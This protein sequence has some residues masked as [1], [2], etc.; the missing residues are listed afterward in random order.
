MTNVTKHLISTEFL[1]K[2]FDKHIHSVNKA[3][4][5]IDTYARTITTRSGRIAKQTVK[6]T[7]SFVKG[8]KQIIDYKKQME[9]AAHATRRMTKEQAKL[10]AQQTTGKHKTNDLVKALRRAVIVAPIWMAARAVMM[11]FLAAIKDIVKEYKELDEGMRKVMAVATYTSSTQAKTYAGLEQA[12][13]IYFATSS[14]GMKEIT[15]AMYQL[16]TA[17]RSTEEIMEGFE[18]ILNLTVATFGDVKIAGRITAGILN[19]FEDE[20][21]EI[22]GTSKQLQYISDL[23]TTAWK[24]NQIELSELNTAMGYLAS[25]G[26]VTGLGLKELVASASVMSDA[27]LRGGKGGRLLARSFI[28]IAKDSKKLKTLGVIF[29]PNKPLDFYNVMKQLRGIYVSQGKSLSFLNDMVGIFGTRGSRAVLSVLDQWQKF[30]EELHRTPEEIEGTAEALKNLAEK[31]W[32]ALFKKA[33][34]QAISTPVEGKGVSPLKEDIAKS[35]LM[36]DELTKAAVELQ[37]YIELQKSLGKE[38]KLSKF[39]AVKLAAELRKVKFL[40]LASEIEKLAKVTAVDRALNLDKA[41]AETKTLGSELL[42]VI[43]PIQALKDLG[44]EKH[45]KKAIEIEFDPGTMMMSKEMSKYGFAAKKAALTLSD[46]NDYFLKLAKGGES[47]KDITKD[48]WVQLELVLGKKTE[49]LEAGIQGRL[50]ELKTT[51]EVNKHVTELSILE[52]N[53]ITS[54]REGLSYKQ[55]E[56]NSYSK[57]QVLMKKITDEI[58][59]Q[60]K[61]INEYNKTHKKDNRETI[62]TYDILSG[63]AEK[64]KASLYG[65]DDVT[66]LIKLGGDAI[67]ETDREKNNLVKTLISHELS[68]LKIK[69]ATS[70]TIA[71]STYDLENQFGINQDILSMLK[72]ELNIEKA[73]TKEKLGQNKISSET[74]KLHKIGEK[75]GYRVMKQIADYSR[76]VSRHIGR[77]AE[78]VMKKEMKG[79]YEERETYEAIKRGYFGGMDIKEEYLKPGFKMPTIDISDIQKRMELPKLPTIVPKVDMKTVI[80]QIEINLPEG[81]LD[82]MAEESGKRLEEKLKTDEDLRKLLANALRPYL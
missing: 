52:K 4:K 35:L 15:E 36:V 67:L 44:L 19:V 69:G 79:K 11:K 62:T 3:E 42:K 50:E 38:I 29:D 49:I 46:I 14:K 16:G 78:M 10:N 30:N 43:K 57:S 37:N 72:K 26:K 51:K 63:N 59:R 21:K 48:W 58:D 31:S 64:L 39:Q 12:A 82:K 22:G 13:R 23:L 70:K 73:I 66:K 54:I 40:K 81:S 1:D 74:V 45:I 68:L 20:L 2:G 5:A 80:E 76:G 25:T 75:Y 32:P 34:H 53:R 41:I 27:L 18:H 24:N 71:E 7:D 33:W 8:K 17:G 47:V 56:L 77:E 61:L 65:I 55:L 28:Q 9:S 60:N 6:V